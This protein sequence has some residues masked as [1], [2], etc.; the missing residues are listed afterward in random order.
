MAMSVFSLG[1]NIGF[2]I[3][4]LALPP[5][6]LLFGPQTSAAIVPAGL[7]VAVP[8]ILVS[9]RI[10]PEGLHRTRRV[11]PV[12][13]TSSRVFP[14]VLLVSVAVLRS[15]VYTASIT[16]L[17]TYLT[18]RGL[19]LTAGAQLLSLML[20]MGTVGMLAGGIASDYFSPKWGTILSLGAATALLATFFAS[21]GI[22]SVVALALSGLFLLWSMAVTTVMAQNLYPGNQALASGLTIGLGIGLGSVGTSI[23]GWMIDLFGITVAMSSLVLVALLAAAILLPYREPRAATV[24]EARAS[25]A[26]V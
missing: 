20:M 23:T 10:K 22:A 4:P 3:A 24:P 21:S 19:A 18:T 11:I 1:G 5:L 6:I 16:F 7:L 14:M 13:R 8:L 25:V 2:T 9:R 15:W 26:G 12:V 17:P